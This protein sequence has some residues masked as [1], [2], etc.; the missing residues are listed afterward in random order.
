VKAARVAR[1]DPE[2]RPR[3]WPGQLPAPVPGRA[4]RLDAGAQGLLLP[5]ADDQRE[6]QPEA[7]PSGAGGERIDPLDQVAQR[8]PSEIHDHVLGRLE[9][10][11]REGLE[12][13][14]PVHLDREPLGRGGRGARVRGEPGAG[15]DDP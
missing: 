1:R 12:R 9:V 11:A 8:E 5:G 4:E 7:V 14:D 10:L 13:L 3:A 15:L 2:E 6:P